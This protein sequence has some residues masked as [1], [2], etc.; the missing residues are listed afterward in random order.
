MGDEWRNIKRALV[1]AHEHVE[2]Q[3]RGRDS[4]VVVQYADHLHE[5]FGRMGVE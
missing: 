1:R 3:L 2:G 5:L 4:K